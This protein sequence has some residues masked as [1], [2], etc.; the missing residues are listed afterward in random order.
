MRQPARESAAVRIAAVRAETAGA[1]APAEAKEE[2]A[3]EYCKKKEVVTEEY[4]PY[5][6]FLCAKFG[7]EKKKNGRS[8]ISV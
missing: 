1:D 4:K 8:I 2:R 3:A 5:G 6:F 7:R